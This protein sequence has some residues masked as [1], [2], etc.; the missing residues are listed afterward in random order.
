LSKP[1]INQGLIRFLDADG[2]HDARTDEIIAR[3]NQSG[4]AWFGG[5]LWHGVRVMRVSVYCYGDTREDISRAITAVK[6]A[7]G[8]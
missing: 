6:K 8:N 5:T 7:Q 3:V 2:N 4:E 1:V